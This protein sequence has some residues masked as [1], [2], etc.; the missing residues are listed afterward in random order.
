MITSFILGSNSSIRLE[1]PVSS[2]SEYSEAE[3][4]F[5]STD[6][7]S[8]GSGANCIMY[9][10]GDPNPAS[11]SKVEQWLNSNKIGEIGTL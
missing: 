10:S 8:E 1:R 6:P 3:S 4:P 7:F 2:T 11:F 5:S 9:S